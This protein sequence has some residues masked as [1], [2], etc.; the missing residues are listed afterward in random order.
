[1]QVTQIKIQNI[2]GIKELEIKPSSITEIT[3]KNASGKTSVLE[4]L[5]SVFAGGKDATLLRKGEKS[6]SV[7]L[8][9]DDGT[10]ITL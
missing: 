7:V 8:L 2:L 5:K 4:A 10:E 3:G 6:G 9:L 1:M